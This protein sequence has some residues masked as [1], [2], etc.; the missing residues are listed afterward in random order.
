MQED[1]LEVE[2]F[3]QLRTLEHMI[4]VPDITEAVDNVDETLAMD[5]LEAVMITDMT[6]I[7]EQDLH[8]IMNS[9]DPVEEV[10]EEVITSSPKME[11]MMFNDMPSFS[12]QDLCNI[13][14]SFDPCEEVL[15]EVIATTSKTSSEDS[16]QEQYVKVKVKQRD[17]EDRCSSSLKRLRKLNAKVLGCHVAEENAAAM[18]VVKRF[19]ERDKFQNDEV[20]FKNLKE[21]SSKLSTCSSVHSLPRD[22]WTGS[23]DVAQASSLVSSSKVMVESDEFENVAGPLASQLSF[24]QEGVDSDC[25]ESSSGGESCDEMQSFKNRHQ[26]KLPM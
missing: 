26:R 15:E 10:V 4:D 3:S 18:Q 12:E 14:Q 19:Q 9:L 25:T 11:A 6:E 21:S 7:S 17:F 13:M 24:L 8:N 2:Q 1:N 23:R 5:E 22:F 16:I 20:F